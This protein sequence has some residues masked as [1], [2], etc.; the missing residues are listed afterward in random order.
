MQRLKDL[1]A[2][3]NKAADKILRVQ[4]EEL[5]WWLCIVIKNGKKKI[6]IKKS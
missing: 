4:L 1:Y 3:G 5:D 6:L 2:D